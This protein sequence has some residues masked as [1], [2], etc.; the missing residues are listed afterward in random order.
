MGIGLIVIGVTCFGSSVFD[1]RAS[2]F[3]FW[4][5]GAHAREDFGG[6]G[7]QPDFFFGVSVCD[8]I[9]DANTFFSTPSTGVGSLKI[10]M[11]SEVLRSG[12][13]FASVLATKQ[14]VDTVVAGNGD[15]CED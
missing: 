11:S 10:L 15:N 7:K 5:P 12:L 3:L 4:D 1:V 2:V 14:E 6:G 13:H 9:S 8:M